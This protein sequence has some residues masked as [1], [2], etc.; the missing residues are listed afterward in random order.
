MA[1][2]TQ[3][4]KLSAQWPPPHRPGLLRSPFQKRLASYTYNDIQNGIRII[5]RALC[6]LA[7]SV[8]HRFNCNTCV[9]DSWNPFYGISYRALV[10]RLATVLFTRPMCISSAPSRMLICVCAC[11]H[12]MFFRSSQEVSIDGWTPGTA[13]SGKPEPTLRSSHAAAL[14]C[15]SRQP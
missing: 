9:V 10:Q 13:R 11:A 6:I 3:L 5:C 15:I 14:P 1:P 4:V 8:P 7:Q 12:G 2:L